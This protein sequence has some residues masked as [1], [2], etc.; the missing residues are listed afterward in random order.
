MLTSDS[1]TILSLRNDEHTDGQHVLRGLVTVP[2]PNQSAHQTVKPKFMAR[3]KA[4]TAQYMLCVGAGDIRDG[5]RMHLQ[6]A[7]KKSV[8]TLKMQ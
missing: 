6:I 2:P 3:T 5:R 8:L 7:E 4:G 1:C